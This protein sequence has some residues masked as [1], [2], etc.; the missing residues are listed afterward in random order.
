MDLPKKSK[1]RYERMY[2]EFQSWRRINGAVCFSERTVLAY[3]SSL[4]KTNKPTTLWAYYSMLKSTL[5]IHHGV[6]ISSYPKVTAFLKR[7]SEG[8]RPR[9]TKVF[10]EA[11]MQSFISDAPDEEWLDVKV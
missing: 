9:K 5:N 8:Y 3:F 4:S 2:N 7:E 10:S 1:D 11:E 6:D